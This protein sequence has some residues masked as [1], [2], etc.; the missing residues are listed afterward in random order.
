MKA[1]IGEY[2][3]IIL[4]VIVSVGVILFLFGRNQT[5]FLGMLHEA[6]PI[7]NVGNDDS[8]QLVDDLSKREVPLLSIK[9]P[10]LSVNKT[11]NLLDKTFFNI[12]AFNADGE[13]MP[14]SIVSVKKDGSEIKDTI[15]LD[16]FHPKKGSYH[17]TYHT[18]EIYKTLKK[19]ANKTIILVAD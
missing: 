13:E 10:K 2:G 17:V 6:K 5:G 16:K 8:I 18:E 4:L 1:L 14:V 3:R 11:Y 19:E 15:E 12:K 9:T 7:A